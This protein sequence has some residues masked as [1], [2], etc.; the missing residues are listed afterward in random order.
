MIGLIAIVSVMAGILAL[1]Y[2]M[3]DDEDN[4]FG[5]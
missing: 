4:Y 5:E 3:L 2:L 1:G